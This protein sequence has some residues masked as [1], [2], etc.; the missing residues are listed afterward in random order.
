MQSVHGVGGGRKELWCPWMIAL[1]LLAFLA[2]DRLRRVLDTLALVG[3]GWTE[4]ADLGRNLADPLA[5]GAGDLDL[6]RL[7]RLD[8]D[9]L[10]DRHLDVMEKPSCSLRFLASAWAR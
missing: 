2:A 9:T 4:A 10:R 6:G 3:L 8:L 5:I 1:L 7:G